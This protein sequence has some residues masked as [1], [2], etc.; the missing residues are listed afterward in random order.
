MEGREC[1]VRISPRFDF[2]K[3]CVLSTLRESEAIA[4]I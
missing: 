1:V 3:L 2:A 4:I